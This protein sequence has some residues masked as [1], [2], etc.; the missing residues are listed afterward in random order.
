MVGGRAQWLNDGSGSKALGSARRRESRQ[1]FREFGLASACAKG[2]AS[3]GGF[4]MGVAD[5]VAQSAAG[6][7][8][9]TIC[10]KPCLGG[11]I[12][13]VSTAVSVSVEQGEII[14]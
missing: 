3:Q 6:Q 9:R 2:P 12:Q 1:V 10:W 4:C 8:E 11:P 14:R 7:S 13:S 5:G